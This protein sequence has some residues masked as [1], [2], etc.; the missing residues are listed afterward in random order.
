MKVDNKVI[1]EADIESIKA[2]VQ[3]R[4]PVDFFCYTLTPE[5]KDRFLKILKVFL[6]ECNQ[7]YLFN[8]LSYCLFEL[9]DNAS[10]ANAKRIYFKEHN[11]NIND[12]NDYKHGMKE[13]KETLD[14]NALHYETELEA[15]KLEVHLLLSAD[16][17]ISITV[18]NNTKITE[19]EY[20]R[21][22]EKIE[23]TKVYNTMA[24]AIN[25][26]DQTEGSGLGIITVLIMLKKLGL[27]S[28]HLQF[29]TTD[30]ETI[31][32]IEIPKDTLEEL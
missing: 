23:K 25:D 12:E 21:I 2:A 9:L 27:A 31:A 15:G 22:K 5:Q 24:D 4:K 3:S 19:S 17:V 28:D 20:K 7:E 30:T 8:Y 29:Q 11:L 14:E 13:F 18:S 32:T 16:D 6:Q 26:I 1:S 10:K